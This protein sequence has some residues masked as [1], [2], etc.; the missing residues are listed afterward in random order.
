MITQT[1]AKQSQTNT[2]HPL[3]FP[4]AARL[5]QPAEPDKHNPPASIPFRCSPHTAGRARQTQSTRFHSLP[6]LASCSRQSQTNTIHPLPFPSVYRLIQ[7][8]TD[9]TPHRPSLHP[10]ILSHI[11]PLTRSA[12]SLFWFC[13]LPCMPVCSTALCLLEEMQQNTGTAPL[14]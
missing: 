6:L 5:T 10:V 13:W 4:S 12:H 8:A 14:P 11:T 7:P 1:T 9:C 2:I 3:P